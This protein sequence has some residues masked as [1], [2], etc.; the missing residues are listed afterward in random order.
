MY[1][2]SWG[3]NRWSRCLCPAASLRHSFLR[4]LW[5]WV[6][7]N[8]SPL[9]CREGDW[10]QSILF[11]LVGLLWNLRLTFAFVRSI[12]W[13]SGRIESQ[14]SSERRLRGDVTIQSLHQSSQTATSGY[15]F[16]LQPGSKVKQWTSGETLRG[17]GDLQQFI[18]GFCSGGSWLTRPR[19]LL[20]ALRHSERDAPNTSLYIRL[21]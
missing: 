15:E 16:P 21:I 11:S 12:T 4:R 17:R 10:C 19:T 9:L 2:E 6:R 18:W 7:G 20:R 14:T 13:F 1:S 8:Y 5:G 3:W